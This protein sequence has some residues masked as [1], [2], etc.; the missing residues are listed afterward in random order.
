MEMENATLDYRVVWANCLDVIK[1]NVDVNAFDTWFVPIVP[2]GLKSDGTLVLQVPSHTYYDCLETHY[3]KLLKRVIRK[4]LGPSGK[5]EYRVVMCQGHGPSSSTTINLPSNDKPAVENQPVRPPIDVYNRPVEQIPDPR[6]VPGIRKRMIPSNLVETLNFDNYVEGDCNRLARAAGWAISKAPGSGTA[7]NPLF[8]YSDVG[9]GKTHLANA[10]GLQTKVNFPDKVVLYISS[11]LFLQQ[12]LESIKNGNRNDFI[13]F[14]QNVDVLIV[15]D[16]QFLA[17]GNKEKTQE[18]F[19]HVFNH[20]YTKGKQIILTS[21]KSPVDLTGFEPRLLNRF[22][23]GL[24]AD[25]QV[26]DLETRI[27]ILRKKLDNQGIE[28]PQE[29]IDYLALRVTSNIRELE[30]AMIAILAQVSLNKREITIDLAKEMIDKYVKS[31]AKDIS[32]EY[33]QKIIC[34]YFKIS[35]DQINT[36]CRKREISQARQ[37]SMFF[38]RKYTKLPLSSIGE[39]CGKRDHATVLHA[40]RTIENLQET[41]KKMKMYIEDIEKKMKI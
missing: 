8:I 10:I 6:Y 16:I 14:Y 9:L 18:A 33:I 28:F 41:D 24:T 25:L 37:L 17:T 35:I 30:G 3:V 39:H 13:F 32:I 22:K 26:P 40:C 11:D 4:E 19:F 23:W 20:L 1:D 5:L 7:F 38:A 36:T 29:V 31:T 12:Y 15:D 27:A 34:D 21:D 2:V